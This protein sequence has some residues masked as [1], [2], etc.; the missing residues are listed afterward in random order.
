MKIVNTSVSGGS[1]VL[2]EN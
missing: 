2:Q 1:E